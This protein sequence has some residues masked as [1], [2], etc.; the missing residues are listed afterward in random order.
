MESWTPATTKTF[1]PE[2]WLPLQRSWY[3][4]GNESF[5]RQ[6]STVFM[7]IGWAQLTF[8]IFYVW[9]IF[10][11]YTVLK[12]FHTFSRTVEALNK[13]LIKFV[14]IVNP[15][16]KDLLGNTVYTMS[17]IIWC[18]FL[19]VWHIPKI[20]QLHNTAFSQKNVLWLHVT[21]KYSMR[22][23]VVQGW[24]Q[25]ASYLTY[26]HKTKQ[27]RLWEN[28]SVRH[29]YHFKHTTWNFEIFFKSLLEYRHHTC[30]LQHVRLRLFWRI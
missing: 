2:T 20:T 17:A 24:D 12:C 14:S 29:R 15:F 18:E 23:Q 11:D 27:S 16:L 28:E 22:M 10:H 26:L 1:R 30:I 4:A 25:L 13:N 7:N 21:M 5:T 19:F 6:C 9:V 8:V 3:L